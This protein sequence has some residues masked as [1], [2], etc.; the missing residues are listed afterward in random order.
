[1]KT[2]SFFYRLM[3]AFCWIPLLLIV[4]SNCCAQDDLMKM[5]ENDST[6]AEKKASAIF[7]STKIINAQSTKTIQAKSTVFRIA[8]RFGD[9]GAQDGKHTLYGFDNSS[10]IRFSFDYGITDKLM[11]GIGR[12]KVKEHLDASIKYKLLEQSSI[13]MIPVAV[14]LFSNVAFTPM[15]DPFNVWTKTIYRLSYAYQVILARNFFSIFSFELLPTIVHRNAV[16]DEIN[17]NNNTVD[18]NTLFSLGAAGKIRITKNISVVADYFYT[19][20]KYRKNNSKTPY[21]AP[22]GI[23]LEVETGGHV[24]HLNITNSA[25]IIENNF[26]PD[27][28]SS[29]EDVEIK[30]GFNISRIFYFVNP[31]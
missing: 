27:T 18:Q 24:F 8:H 4:G 30:L 10:N 11:V 22:L 31:K 9:I 29:W 6:L 28:N 3:P 23:G 5:L 12:S 20:S 26:I 2:R 17:E 14:A 13:K 1:M 21:Y 7:R 25:G 19:F 15:K 16:L